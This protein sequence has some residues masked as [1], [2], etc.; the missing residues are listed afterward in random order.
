MFYSTAPPACSLLT[1][2]LL[3]QMLKCV[4][5]NIVFCDFL[6]TTGSHY[7]RSISHSTVLRGSCLLF[8]RFF[9]FLI[10]WFLFFSS[11]VLT[12]CIVTWSCSAFALIP[13]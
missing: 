10:F 8:Y 4:N 11:C 13:R 9:N 2:L 6:Y 5:C 7:S 3:A 1:I 12:S